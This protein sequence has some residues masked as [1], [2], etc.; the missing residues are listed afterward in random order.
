MKELIYGS[1]V[2]FAVF[3][4]VKLLTSSKD[5]S[6]EY[7]AIAAYTFGYTAYILLGGKLIGKDGDFVFQPLFFAILSFVLY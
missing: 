6:S 3:V 7:S 4:V 5:G 1:V 2:C